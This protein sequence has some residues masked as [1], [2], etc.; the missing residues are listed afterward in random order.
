MTTPDDQRGR[1]LPMKVQVSCAA[2]HHLGRVGDVTAVVTVDPTRW[3][4]DAAD[5]LRRKGWRPTL[6]SVAR[7]TATTSWWCPTHAGD[8]EAS[9]RSLAA[10]GRACPSC[11]HQTHFPEYVNGQRTDR[12]TKSARQQAQCP[13]RGCRCRHAAH[14]QTDPA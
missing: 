9:S 3:L 7:V 10:E 11:L 5:Q 2:M 1:V 13:E 8:Y 4:A 14:R 6:G 12:Y